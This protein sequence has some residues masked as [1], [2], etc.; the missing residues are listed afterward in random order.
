MS[1]T[2]KLG[3]YI[4]ITDIY[5][6]YYLKIGEVIDIDIDFDGEPKSYS[7]QFGY[8]TEISV[9]NV[10]KYESDLLEGCRVLMFENR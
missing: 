9:G 4:L 3:D 2:V 1:Q 10:V 6:G 7:V 5:D 8:D